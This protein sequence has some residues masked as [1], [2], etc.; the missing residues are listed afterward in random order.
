MKQRKETGKTKTKTDKIE[1]N[2]ENNKTENKWKRRYIKK[3]GIE[4]L[5][6][7]LK[8]KEV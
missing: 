1:L 4:A 5:N 6:E 8:V 7:K 2:K 3:T